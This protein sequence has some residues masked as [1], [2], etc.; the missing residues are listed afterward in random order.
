MIEHGLLVLARGA[1]EVAEEAAARDHHLVGGVLLEVL[2]GNSIGLKNR[3][4]IGPKNCPS[5]QKG[6]K[7][8]P[9]NHLKNHLNDLYAI[10]LPPCPS[11]PSPDSSCDALAMLFIMMAMTFSWMPRM[12]TRSG[13][14]KNTWL[15]T[16]VLEGSISTYQLPELGRTTHGELIDR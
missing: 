10:E 15:F 8:G 2:G 4:K 5:I 16:R 6:P 9:E 1:A 7:T 13:C 12:R 14:W 11:P 3:P